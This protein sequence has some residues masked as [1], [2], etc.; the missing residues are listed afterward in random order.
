MNTFLGIW[1]TIGAFYFMWSMC[2][3]LFFSMILER[4]KKGLN[5]ADK[6]GDAMVDFLLDEVKIDSIAL[7]FAICIV[8][9]ILLMLA[10]LVIW[11]YALIVDL[12]SIKRRK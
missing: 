6:I 2:Y 9:G 4:E 8:F 11:P 7:G 3:V 10:F 5:L 12:L 1:V